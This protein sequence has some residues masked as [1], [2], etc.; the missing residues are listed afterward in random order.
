[1]ADFSHIRAIGFQLQIDRICKGERLGDQE[2]LEIVEY[3]DPPLLNPEEMDVVANELDVSRPR[4]RGRPAG[5]IAPRKLVADHIESISRPDIP[6]KFLKILAERLRSGRRFPYS[7]RAR[8]AYREN[9]AS[10]MHLFISALYADA[11]DAM[12]VGKTQIQYP[13]MEPFEF[14]EET[15]NYSLHERAL[16]AVNHIMRTYLDVD[17]PSER[18]MLNI[19]SE[20]R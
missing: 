9:R 16:R 2:L 5:M 1:M 20:K 7:V 18:R 6:E 11:K 15:G 12:A 17:P 13:E 19:I 4:K 3:F 10:K 8:K 14:P